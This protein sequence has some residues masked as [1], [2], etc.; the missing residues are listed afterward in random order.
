MWDKRGLLKRKEIVRL[1]V[2]AKD[3]ESNLILRRQEGEKPRRDTGGN[4][5]SSSGLPG[6]GAGPRPPPPPPPRPP[7]SMYLLSSYYSLPADPPK[8][9]LA[10][11]LQHARFPAASIAGCGGLNL[12]RR[13]VQRSPAGPGS[14]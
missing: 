11:S 10:F 5:D 6:P 1:D 9:S 13:S 12:S 4:V 3:P 8:P 14:P 2:G 7:V